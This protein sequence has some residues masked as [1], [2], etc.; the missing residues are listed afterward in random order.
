MIAGLLL[1]IPLLRLFFDWMAGLVSALQAATNSGMRLVFGYLAGGPTPFD[2]VKPQNSFV[3]AFQ[4]LPLILVISALSRLLYYWGVLQKLVGF[5][6]WGLRRTLGVSGAVGTAAAANLFV[7]MVESPLLIKPYLARMSRS[8]LFAVMTTGMA[9]VAGTVLVLY[10]TIL[11]AAI[12][13]AAG[14]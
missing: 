14:H 13:G 7:G 1:N 6:A 4:A 9:T 8:E 2:V 12:D 3:L 10:A 5:F 11:G